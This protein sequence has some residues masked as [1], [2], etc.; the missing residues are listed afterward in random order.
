MPSGT[1]IADR[2]RYEAENAEL[3][4]GAS[5]EE[6]YNSSE[7]KKVTG[8]SNPNAL[9]TFNVNVVEAGTYKLY[10]G[11]ATSS[12]NAEI[13]VTVNSENEF[14]KKVLPFNAS[15]ANGICPDNWMGYE[16]EIEL[17]AG[18]NT[19]A[20]GRAPLMGVADIDYIELEKIVPVIDTVITA[21]ESALEDETFEIVMTTANAV[22][23]I[24]VKNENGSKMGSKTVSVVDNGD[25]T[26]TAVAQMSVATVGTGRTFT[27]YNG[28][29]EAGSFTIDINAR[30]IEAGIKSI[31]APVSAAAGA[32]FEVTGVTNRELKAYRFEDETGKKIGSSVDSRTVYQGLAE[33]VYEMN[34]GTAGDRTVTLKMTPYGD[35]TWPY[36]QS[37]DI[38]I[39]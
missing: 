29:E 10:V 25:G 1:P 23:K 13:K 18:D 31:S 16:I 17:N 27:V 26:Y 15:Q 34:I 8:F 30:D 20:I 2:V 38:T 7:G 36:S 37:F 28:Q 5:I 12:A 33:T 19:I 6:T 39:A 32:N 4:G 22:D 21:P 3:T 14:I 11:A 35:F 9:A 24:T